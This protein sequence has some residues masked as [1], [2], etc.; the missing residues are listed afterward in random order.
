MIYFPFYFDITDKE[1]L[2]IGGG[3]IAADKFMRLRAFTDKIRIVAKETEIDWPY[4][5]LREY[6]PSDLA[7]AAYCVAATGDQSLDREI[8]SDCRKRGIPVNV[9]DNAALCDFIFPAII[10]KGKLIAS[11][12]TSGASPAYARMLKEQIAQLL[13]PDI[14]AVLD[15]MYGLRAELKSAG[16]SQAERAEIYRKKLGE[17][18][19]G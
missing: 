12:S 10:K 9:P 15:K 19:G 8:A 13:P 4:I 16:L 1:F 6:R 14:E 5:T 17:L 2:L 11:V 3:S 18:L 7:G